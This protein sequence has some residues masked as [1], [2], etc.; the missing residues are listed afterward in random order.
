MPSEKDSKP[1]VPKKS[2]SELQWKQKLSPEAFRVCRQ[3][4]TEAPFSGQWVMCH[5]DGD[6]LCAC[7]QTPLFSSKTKFDSGSGWPSFFDVLAQDYIHEQP[8]HALNV[9]RVEVCCAVC[10][11]HLGHVFND[12]PPPTGKRYCINSVALDFKAK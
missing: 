12:G 7:C 1:P 6:Y 8:D 11:A 4:G 3:K 5:Q 10:D 2:L 9:P